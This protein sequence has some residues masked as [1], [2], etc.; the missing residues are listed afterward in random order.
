[1]ANKLGTP[2]YGQT[3]AAATLPAGRGLTVSPRVRWNWHSDLRRI[4]PLAPRESLMHNNMPIDPF[5]HLSA[6]TGF[7]RL[8]TASW[9]A[10]IGSLS[11]VRMADSVGG[12]WERHEEGRERVGERQVFRVPGSLDRGRA[13]AGKAVRRE[14]CC[15]LPSRY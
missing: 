14:N 12:G 4:G 15:S 3:V 1:M 2:A 11:T 10:K 7:Y 8:L 9:C 5:S 13:E 6:A